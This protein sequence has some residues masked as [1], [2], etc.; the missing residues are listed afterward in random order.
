MLIGEAPGLMEARFGIPFVGPT[1]KELDLTYLPLSGLCRSDIF[2]TNTVSCHW[3][4]SKDAPPQH[5]VDSCSQFRLRAELEAVKPKFVVL[6]GGISNSLLGLRQG[7]D[8]IHGTARVANL[9]GREYKVFSTY[10]PALGMHQSSAMTAL[11]IDFEKLGLFIRDDV[12]YVKDDHPNP[13]L[14]RITNPDILDSVLEGQWDITHLAIDTESKKSW[15]GYS[16]TVKWTP[17]SI[18]FSVSPYDGYL[19]K[20]EDEDVVARFGYHALKFRKVIM[21]NAPHDMDILGRC[22]IH[23]DWKRVED[24]MMLAYHDA[25]LPKGLKALSYQLA[26][27]EMRNFEDVVVPYGREAAARYLE[28]AR[29]LTWKDPKQEP[30]GEMETRKCKDCK[31]AGVF[32]VGRGKARK[33]YQCGC[34]EGYVTQPK[35]TRRQGIGQKIGRL[36]TDYGKNPETV[37]P[38]ER[39]IN[40]GDGV[41]EL[42]ERLGPLPLP[43]VELVPEDEILTYAASDSISTW[44]VYP[45]LVSRLVEIRRRFSGKG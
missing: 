29:T 40:W 36:L 43:S 44:R 22:G 35:M 1:G 42:I 4:D 21:H 13:G 37:D 17:W 24:T 10:H 32:G 26:G 20:V 23:P 15:R 14:F 7:V 6:M 28:H 11:L 19:I 3:A 16:S 27:I 33:L 18:Q 25:R 2:V 8:M 5:I 12:G 45:I 31:G 30:T 9:F 38:V 41:E 34:N 39:W